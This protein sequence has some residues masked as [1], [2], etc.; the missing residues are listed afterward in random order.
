M[1]CLIQAIKSCDATELSSDQLTLSQIA[2]ATITSQ[3]A[4][5]TQLIPKRALRL[6]R[7]YVLNDK[8]LM[9]YPLLQMPVAQRRSLPKDSWSP[10]STSPLPI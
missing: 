4:R 6:R 1:L 8:M 7:N 9:K 10:F 3:T 5:P 2:A